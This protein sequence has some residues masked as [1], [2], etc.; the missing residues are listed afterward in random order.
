MTEQFIGSTISVEVGGGLGY[1]QGIVKN[2]NS[3][4]QRITLTKVIHNGE[5][6]NKSEVI[7]R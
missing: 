2:I 3:V 7:L 4:D 1:Y 6:M 5:P